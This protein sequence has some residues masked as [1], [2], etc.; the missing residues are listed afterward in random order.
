MKN[1]TKY[2]NEWTYSK[3][4]RGDPQY[5]VPS[6]VELI[7]PENF[8]AIQITNKDLDE[9]DTI[10]LANERETYKFSDEEGIDDDDFKYHIDSW[11]K[12]IAQNIS[13]I[14]ETLLKFEN[15]PDIDKPMYIVLIRGEEIIENN[16]IEISTKSNL[17]E[18]YN[19]I[20]NILKKDFSEYCNNIDNY[21]DVVGDDRD[22][23]D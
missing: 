14:K 1:Y 23:N 20:M 3:G 11:G 8:Y 7:I 9:I 13:W 19:Q 17:D 22:Y 16:E 21:K 12:Q 4:H 10:N 5:E 2:L 15:D 6:Y 18:V